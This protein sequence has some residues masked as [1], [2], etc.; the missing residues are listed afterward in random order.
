MLRHHHGAP[1]RQH[2]MSR[3]GKQA[4][5]SDAT[6]SR[7]R[8]STNS[9]RGRDEGFPANRF[10]H[11]LHFDHWKGLENRDIVH[12]RILRLDGDERR[13]FQER[14]LRLGWGF[15]YEDPICI[16]VSMVREFCA[17]FS[18]AKQD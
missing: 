12:E 18:S 2:Q 8:A 17:N 6:P 4:A 15:M 9:S 7:V 1:A 10:D 13:V 16:N 3:R 11:Q 5:T 14:I